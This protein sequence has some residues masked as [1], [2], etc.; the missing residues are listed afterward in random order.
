MLGVNH[1]APIA[2]PGTQPARPGKFDIPIASLFPLSPVESMNGAENQLLALHPKPVNFIGAAPAPVPIP[3]A[4]M[5]LP[6]FFVKISSNIPASAEATIYLPRL[7]AHCRY[8]KCLRGEK[9]AYKNQ[10]LPRIRVINH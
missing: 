2:L 10:V 8:H 6:I 9:E 1:L 4:A 3:V 7:A 5:H